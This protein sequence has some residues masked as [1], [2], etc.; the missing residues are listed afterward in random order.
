MRNHY[1]RIFNSSEETE[2]T[3][4]ECERLIGRYEGLIERFF[5]YTSPYLKKTDT[6]DYSEPY[7]IDED[8]LIPRVEFENPEKVN[9]IISK[10]SRNIML[11]QDDINLF[12]DDFRKLP[13]G[14]PCKKIPKEKEINPF[15]DI[16]QLLFHLTCII[17]LR[18]KEYEIIHQNIDKEPL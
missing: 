11:L 5:K 1:I 18:K 8:K 6:G 12:Y 3:I 9:R 14:H 17:C 16:S 15:Y 2:D 4:K 10:E 13:I 7:M